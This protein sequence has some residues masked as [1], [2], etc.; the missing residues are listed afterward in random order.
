MQVD[1]IDLYQFHRPSKHIAID[2]SLRAMDDLVRSGKVRYIGT[3]NFGSW[4]VVE[5][6]WASKELG[7]NRF[8]SDQS[9]YNMADR[10]IERE[11]IPMCQT[12]GLAQIPWSPLAG[13]GLT[14]KYS[15]SKIRPKGSRYA[16]ETDPKKQL[17]MSNTVV[18]IVDALIPIAKSK[19]CTISQLL[20]LIHI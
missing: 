7:L 11:H 4:Q 5:A 15:K 17:R 12:Y 19:G 2:E 9:P 20:S 14:G 16:D 3:S 8:V 6:L 18:D 1:H 10:R 13:G